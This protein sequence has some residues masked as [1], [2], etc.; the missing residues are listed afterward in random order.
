MYKIRIAKNPAG[1][2]I[3]TKKHWWSRWITKI[4]VGMS[5]KAIEI[6]NKTINDE[7]TYES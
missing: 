3:Q 4:F 5:S 2:E 7:S 6:A 1:Y